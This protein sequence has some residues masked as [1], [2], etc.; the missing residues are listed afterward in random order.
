MAKYWHA[1]NLDN[2]LEIINKGLLTSKSCDNVIYL[3][4]KEEDAVKF[5]AIR[6]IKEILVCEV[7]VDEGFIHESFDHNEKFFGCK[8]Y[9]CEKDIPSSN[10]LQYRK[11]LNPFIKQK[12]ENA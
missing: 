5:P 8:A 10:I 9:F 4:E 11:W 2:I 3:C 1:T 12:E 6:G 7:E